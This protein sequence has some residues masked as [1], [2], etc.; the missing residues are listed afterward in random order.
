MSTLK[1]GESLQKV[2]MLGFEARMMERS[3][4]VNDLVSRLEVVHEA[5]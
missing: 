5:A 4:D 1:Q 3:R 2:M